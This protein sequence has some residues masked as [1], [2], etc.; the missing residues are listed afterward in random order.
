MYTVLKHKIP[1]GWQWIG[2]ATRSNALKGDKIWDTKEGKFRSLDGWEGLYDFAGTTAPYVRPINAR[3]PIKTPQK[4]RPKVRKVSVAKQ[5]IDLLLEVL[6][7]YPNQDPIRVA[8]ALADLKMPPKQALETLKK[9]APAFS[10]QDI[11]RV[12]AGYNE[13][14]KVVSPPVVPKV[15]K[16]YQ[17]V[18]H[19]ETGKYWSWGTTVWSDLTNARLYEEEARLYPLINEVIVVVEVSE[20]GSRRVIT[21]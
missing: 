16:K 19:K 12:V 18:K 21:P 13:T 7:L 10:G 11:I 4:P 6:K 1:K 8:G 2:M 9:L 15:I 5:A 14:L 20:D 17:V 3:L